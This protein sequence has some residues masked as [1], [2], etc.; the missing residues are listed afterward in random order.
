MTDSSSASPG[1][2][3][4]D[5]SVVDLECFYLE[6]ILLPRLRMFLFSTVFPNNAGTEHK[7]L[8][9]DI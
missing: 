9:Q 4:L 1:A 6:A 3:N 7:Y 5:L 2:G 8:L